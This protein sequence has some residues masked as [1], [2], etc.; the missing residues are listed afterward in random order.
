MTSSRSSGLPRESRRAERTD[1]ERW[2]GIMGYFL[3]TLLMLV[4]LFLMFVILLQ[5]G[6]GGGL[7]GAFGGLGG[8]SAFGTKAGDIFTIIT[9]VAVCIWVILAC[10]TGYRLNYEENHYGPKGG[11]PAAVEPDEIKKAPADKDRDSSDV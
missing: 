1:K 11:P 2:R 6:R 7:A 9:I 3:L 4:S 8:Q 10:L 5:R